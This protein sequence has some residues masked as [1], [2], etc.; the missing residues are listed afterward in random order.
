M[1]EDYLNSIKMLEKKTD[2]NSESIIGISGLVF[3]VYY[4]RFEG[5]AIRLLNEN[6]VETV[7]LLSLNKEKGVNTLNN[8]R[9][10][11]RYFLFMVFLLG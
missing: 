11:S 2:K 4:E 5:E 6:T 9:I 7:C 3:Q 1:E 8:Q 10:H